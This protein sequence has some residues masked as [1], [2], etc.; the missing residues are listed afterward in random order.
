MIRLSF[1]CFP[2]T[3]LTCSTFSSWFRFTS[4]I[5]SALCALWHITQLYWGRFHPGYTRAYFICLWFI[6]IGRACR[7]KCSFAFDCFLAS[8]VLIITTV[9]TFTLSLFPY[10]RI[11]AALP[12]ITVTD[13]MSPI[14]PDL[15]HMH[16]CQ[17]IVRDILSSNESTCRT[18]VLNCLK[19][20]SIH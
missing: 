8:I 17:S 19:R 15:W 6:R 2:C 13:L 18:T 11:S 16:A 20:V 14:T 7:T 12:N 10:F 5:L 3:G 9:K 1:H 4:V